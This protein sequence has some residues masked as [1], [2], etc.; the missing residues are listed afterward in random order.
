[1]IRI[2]A[3]F[4]GL[5]IKMLTN[6]QKQAAFR[7]RKKKL[8]LVRCD[9]IYATPKRKKYFKAIAKNDERLIKENK[10]V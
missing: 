9:D 3:L 6:A 1:M 5:T 4:S 8:G 2:F 7:K 10:N